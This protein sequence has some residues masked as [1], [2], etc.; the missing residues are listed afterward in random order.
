M[1]KIKNRVIEV[2]EVADSLCDDFDIGITDFSLD[3]IEYI[4]METQMSIDDVCEIL[5]IAVPGEFNREAFN[6]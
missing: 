4:A 3:D 5:E 6:D 2:L 1:G